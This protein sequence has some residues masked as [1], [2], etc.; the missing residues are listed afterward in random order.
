[1]WFAPLVGCFF[2]LPEKAECEDPHLWYAPDGSGDTYFGCE[3]PEGW[4]ETPADESL[5]A[6]ATTTTTLHDDDDEPAID[7]S[8]PAITFPPRDTSPPE[9][10]VTADTGGIGPVDTSIPPDTS[11]TAVPTE[12]T[13]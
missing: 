11:D 10:Q 6:A 5:Y 3:P 4:K 7:T 2:S 9:P 8:T 12:D 1:M 13:T